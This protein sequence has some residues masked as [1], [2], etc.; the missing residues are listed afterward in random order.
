MV[1]R[2]YYVLTERIGAGG[3]GA[4]WAATYHGIGSLQTEVA[5][6]VYHAGAP[7]SEELAT[8]L[9]DEGRVLGF[10]L[11]RNIVVVRRIVVVNGQHALEMERIRGCDLGRV[12][13]SEM[14]PSPRAAL[15]I[16]AEAASALDFAWTA[17]D[18]EGRPL[19]VLHRD[20]KPSNIA[21]TP[22]GDVKVLDFGIAKAEL[23]VRESRT[24]A[25]TV[26]GTMDFMASER[27]EGREGPEADVY[28]LGGVL[29]ALLTG[30]HFGRGR[31]SA[32]AHERMLVGACNE[33]LATLDDAWGEG[34]AAPI[35][36]LLYRTLHF[37]PAERPTAAELHHAAHALAD[38]APGPTLRAWAR[39][40]VPALQAAHP[41]RPS[42]DDGRVLEEQSERSIAL[43]PAQPFSQAI[44]IPP[45]APTLPED[46]GSA[47]PGLEPVA[48]SASVR[49]EQ[50]FPE[51]PQTSTPMPTAALTDERARTARS[52]GWT[53][54]GVVLGAGVV[55][56]V[57]LAL[58]L[59]ASPPPIAEAPLV[60]V[61][62]VAVAAAPEIE[63]PAAPEVAAPPEPAAPPE[64]ARVRVGGEARAAT[65]QGNGRRYRLPAAIPP[66]EYE[67]AADFGDGTA[68]SAGSVTVPASGSLLLRCRALMQVCEA[69]PR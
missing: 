56:A 22:D 30:R 64:L 31:A 15:S 39:E 58:V 8:R 18:R 28:S 38:A 19:R 61:A 43:M 46:E 27:F 40:S 2:P 6:K 34:T 33:L 37:D 48:L 60:P 10:L 23:A 29:F 21:L 5:L 55:V 32:A 7:G 11:H 3:F 47:D 68:V 20:I 16:V 17:K 63:T 41:P 25:D 51:T 57:G 13:Q 52:Q 45:V 49:H 1:S 50:P 12:V 62:A 42:P 65:L 4:V 26:P 44:G 53:L 14:R 69:E 35:L 67:I 9:R 66:G 24:N 36:D 54:A 59:R